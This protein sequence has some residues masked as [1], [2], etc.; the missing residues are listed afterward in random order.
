[1]RFR[2]KGQ[3][4]PLPASWE[5][6]YRDLPR[7]PGAHPALLIYQG[8]VLRGCAA[9]HRSTADPALELPTGTGKPLPG[10]VIAHWVRQVHSARV[11]GRLTVQSVV[12]V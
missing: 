12:A 10:L 11:T 7:N 9:G 1:M 3:T 6:L 5:A 2:G 4:R 8:G